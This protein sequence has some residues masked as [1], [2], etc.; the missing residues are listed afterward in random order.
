MT[1]V[2][3]RGLFFILSSAMIGG[4]I[5]AMTVVTTNPQESIAGFGFYTLILLP[6]VYSRMRTLGVSLWNL[7]L[8]VTPFT[9]FMLCV[10]LT[11]VS[12][13]AVKTERVYVL[14]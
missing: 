6:M 1:N 12:E 8:A 9:L 7:I 14:K 5:H 11:F 3:T 13:K 4:A 10:Y 2:F